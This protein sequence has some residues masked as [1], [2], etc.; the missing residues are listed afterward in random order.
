MFGVQAFQLSLGSRSRRSPPPLQTPLFPAC[1]NEEGKPALQA[2]VEVFRNSRPQFHKMAM[3]DED[4]P[5]GERR[6]IVFPFN[7]SPPSSGI[8]L[9][10]GRYNASM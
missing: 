10:G 7:P 2:W 9:Y 3:E 5:E 1:R 8:C 4:V 6:V